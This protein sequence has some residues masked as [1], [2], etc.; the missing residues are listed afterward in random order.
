MPFGVLMDN[1]IQASSMFN[2]VGLRYGPILVDGIFA[3]A[4]AA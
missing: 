4:L 1:S 2:N 3:Q